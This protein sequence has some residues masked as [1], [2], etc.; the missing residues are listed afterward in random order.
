MTPGYG[1]GPT[2]S[3]DTPAGWSPDAPYSVGAVHQMDDSP[4]R[5]LLGWVRERNRCRH[6]S[7]APPSPSRREAPRDLRDGG[8][9][10]HPRIGGNRSGEPLAAAGTDD[11]HLAVRGVLRLDQGRG[12]NRRHPPRPLPLAGRRQRP[13]DL[14]GRPLL[15][16]PQ[17]DDR[18]GGLRG[19]AAARGG[20]PPGRAGLATSR[21][22]RTTRPPTSSS[23]S[24][25]LLHVLEPP[26][27]VP[28]DAGRERGPPGGLVPAA[29]LREQPHGVGLE[30]GDHEIYVGQERP[31]YL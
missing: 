30:S 19:R 21:A 6:R 5:G 17:T 3:R 18:P 31:E 25:A 14:R 1:A 12:G 4:G 22:R 20:P 11:P 23:S 29:V 8:D 9:R 15:G 10:G 27:R 26:D 7:C 13:G 16:R 28:T 24:R 2:A